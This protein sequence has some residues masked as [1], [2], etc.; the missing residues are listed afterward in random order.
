MLSLA[1][2]FAVL[3]YASPASAEVKFS[4]DASIRLR[5]QFTDTEWLGMEDDEDD[6]TF[7]YRVRLKAA[8]D[9]GSGYFFKAML[10]TDNTVGGWTTLN[11]NLEDTN[12][13]FSNFYF[14]RMME[15]SHYMMGRLPLNSVNNPIFDLALSPD[16]PLDIPV[17]TVFMDRVLGLNYGTKIGGGELNTTLV[18]LNEDSDDDSALEGDGMFNDGY[19]LH[20]SYKTNIGKV[21]FE[22]QALIMLTDGDGMY[23]DITPHTFGANLTVPAGDA[24][25]GV[26]GFYTVCDDDIVDYSGYLL[27][28]KGEIGAFTA[29]V[30]YSHTDDN[31]PGALTTDYDNYFVWAQYKYNVYESAMGSFSLT[32]TVRYLAYSDNFL[33]ADYDY[34]RLRTELIATV[35]F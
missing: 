8:A 14:G 34:S 16:A 33:G 3:A 28:L 13:E 27:R 4:G 7:A 19:A 1:A 32:P 21:T 6:L 12:I 11:D 25:I 18:L 20:L 31:T 5:G 22:P 26:S 23:N 30:D 9:M 17:A 35:T 15:N 24:K 2:M 29:W 10:T